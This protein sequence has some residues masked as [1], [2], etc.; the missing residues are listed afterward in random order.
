MINF[1]SPDYRDGFI[2]MTPTSDW[3]LITHYKEYQNLLVDIDNS[4]SNNIK[5]IDNSLKD[6]DDCDVSEIS[7]ETFK[8]DSN[9]KL[10]DTFRN[11]S[12][13]IV[14]TLPDDGIRNFYSPSKSEAGIFS[15]ALEALDKGSS[16]FIQNY[17]MAQQMYKY[18]CKFMELF[19]M[20]YELIELIKSSHIMSYFDKEYRRLEE[21]VASYKKF[22]SYRQDDDTRV[23]LDPCEKKQAMMDGWY[24]DFT[25]P[26]GRNTMNLSRS[27]NDYNVNIKRGLSDLNDVCIA[28]A[29]FFD[30]L[31]LGV[32]VLAAINITFYSDPKDADLFRSQSEGNFS[33]MVFQADDDSSDND[34]ILRA[35]TLYAMS[36]SIPITLD[37]IKYIN[38]DR[39]NIATIQGQL[40]RSVFDQLGVTDRLDKIAKTLSVQLEDD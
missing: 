22:I 37:S 11:I 15:N 8:T 3:T 27:I 2:S 38:N 30:E 6:D 32:K 12:S 7:W 24:N 34:R 13:D 14:G 9:N 31:Y 25:D 17:A 23:Y 4:L 36:L 40:V 10:K 33:Y 28:V 1:N 21:N 19:R 18:E 20:V 5:A 16:N 26:D 29:N 39:S 35:R